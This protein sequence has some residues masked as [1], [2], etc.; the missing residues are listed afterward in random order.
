ML[1]LSLL[2]YQYFHTAQNK[3][4]ILSKLACLG[5]MI[6]SNSVIMGSYIL[7]VNVH[8][9]WLFTFSGLCYQLLYLVI[10]VLHFCWNI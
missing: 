8:C 1:P 6:T 9:R 10:V 7:L 5:L 2:F 4:C 3:C